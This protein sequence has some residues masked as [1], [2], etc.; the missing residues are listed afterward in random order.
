[1][2]LSRQHL[3]SARQL[4]QMVRD[5]IELAKAELT[6]F[7]LFLGVEPLEID[8]LMPPLR[9][10]IA[11]VAQPH[12][13]VELRLCVARFEARRHSPDEA[14]KHLRI[15]ASL[16]DSYPN[17]WLR[18]VLALDSSNVESLLGDIDASLTYAMEA[19]SCAQ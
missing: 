19:M 6:H 13:M 9:R 11:R 15:V 4:S 3:S 10:L 8:V 18:G 17:L 5:D 12:L 14:K 16:L 1:L 7:S 2:E